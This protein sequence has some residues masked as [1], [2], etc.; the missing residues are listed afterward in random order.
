MSFE[1]LVFSVVALNPWDYNR[2]LKASQPT[3]N[4]NK[5]VFRL[6]QKLMCNKIINVY[7]KDNVIADP[8]YQQYYLLC[9]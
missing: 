7:Y 2:F 9:L 6:V 5:V 1:M 8:V 3:S 4:Q